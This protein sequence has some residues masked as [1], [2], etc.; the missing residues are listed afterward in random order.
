MTATKKLVDIPAPL[1][2]SELTRFVLDQKLLKE[3]KKAL[4]IL[5][6]DLKA[7]E[8]DLIH[9]LDAG[10]KVLSKVYRAAVDRSDTRRN[11]GWKD[12]AAGLWRKLGQ[13]PR[14]EAE[15]LLATVE[16]TV[17]AHLVVSEN[18]K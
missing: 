12:I 2:E 11:V 3:Q 5:E 16:P 17:Y 15:K 13:D 14:L 8:R 6:N 10:A 7:R 9:R 1:T 18:L 4:E